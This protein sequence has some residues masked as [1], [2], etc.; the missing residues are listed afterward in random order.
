MI[1]SCCT[2]V[3]VLKLQLSSVNRSGAIIAYVICVLK[4][5]LV[6]LL[7]AQNSNESATE[8]HSSKRVELT[9]TNLRTPI[10]SP[11]DGGPTVTL[12]GAKK[13]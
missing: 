11:G 8:R 5:P 6:E 12:A 9:E 3:L 10:V 4:E 7:K 2:C 13:P 1:G